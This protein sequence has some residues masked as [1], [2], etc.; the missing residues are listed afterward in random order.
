ME[1]VH[2]GSVSRMSHAS[3]IKRTSVAS[4]A[5]LHEVAVDENHLALSDSKSIVA[6]FPLISFLTFIL[7]PLV[8]PTAEV[9]S[10]LLIGG[11]S[12]VED[13]DLATLPPPPDFL[14]DA[15]PEGDEASG[16]SSASA[17]EK[18]LIAERSLSVAEAVKTLNEIR[19]QPASP[20]VV[21]RVQSMR[22]ASDS[23]GT[24][25]G[26]NSIGAD[27]IDQH[28]RLK[29]GA[30][31]TLPKGP[32]TL[33][34]G[35]RLVEQDRTAHIGPHHHHNIRTLHHPL[36]HQHSPHHSPSPN[37]S[38]VLGAK[39]A[40]NNHHAKTLPKVLPSQRQGHPN[41][42]LEVC[43]IHLSQRLN[44]SL[45]FLLAAG[46]ATLPSSG[47]AD[48]AIPTATAGYSGRSG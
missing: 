38:K 6:T 48:S 10:S 22:L 3:T 44:F 37:S 28:F 33:P 27:V 26:P 21:R 43:V 36:H 45:D 14:L 30:H 8:T 46:S 2:R 19:H 15:A 25:M 18:N 40:N 9:P 29:S 24:G 20:G 39:A 23:P 31:G 34:K 35:R 41:H 1:W 17:A 42:P 4:F 7:L 13:V 32:G 47:S 11:S 16:K 12:S 5:T